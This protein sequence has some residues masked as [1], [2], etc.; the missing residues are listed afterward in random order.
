MFPAVLLHVP[1]TCT[2]IL[3]CILY[4]EEKVLASLEELPEIEDGNLLSGGQGNWASTVVEDISQRIMT[5]MRSPLPL[6]WD[7]MIPRSVGINP[8]DWT[9]LIISERNTKPILQTE[10]E[11]SVIEV[12]TKKEQLKASPTCGREEERARA[13]EWVSVA[14]EQRSSKEARSI[15]LESK[16]WR[17]NTFS[18]DDPSGVL[19]RIDS[20]ESEE[21]M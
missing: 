5:V 18:I 20:C 14:L 7:L 9:S 13:L 12:K 2:C 3:S 17:D 6:Q 19:E 8:T 4:E 1:C 16:R 15:A 21:S 10:M 11:F